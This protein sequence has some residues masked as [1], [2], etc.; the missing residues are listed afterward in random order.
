MNNSEKVVLTVDHLSYRYPGDALGHDVL[1]DVSFYLEHHKTVAL[2]GASGVGKSTF[3]HLLGLLDIPVSG[4]I[5]FRDGN[6]IIWTRGL[7]DVQRTALRGNF[8][9][10]VYQFHHLLG[11]FTALE[12]VMLPQLIAGTSY[13]GAKKKAQ[14]L[15]ALVG[16][17]DRETYM[18]SQLSGGQKQRVAI[19]R[20]LIN[21]PDILLADEPTG[22]LDEE[23]AQQVFNLFLRLSQ[24][25][26]LS[27]L[28]ATH[29]PALSAQFD[30]VVYMYSG[31]LHQQPQE[32]TIGTE[33]PNDI[34]CAAT[35]G[36]GNGGS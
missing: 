29:N 20:A 8:I 19:A 35:K 6:Q 18:P 4:D 16:L 10:F 7:K 32:R 15:L 13:T 24:E 3:L 14:E 23:S 27:V 33:Q 30:R 17:A 12:N 2:M 22:N 28:M 25:R 9:G 31:G 21:E 26:G 11:E 36:R 5:G 1:R 34:P